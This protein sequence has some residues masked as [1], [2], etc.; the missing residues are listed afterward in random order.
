MRISRLALASALFWSSVGACGFS[1]AEHDAIWKARLLAAQFADAQA[2]SVCE[3]KP[4]SPLTYVDDIGPEDGILEPAL[5]FMVSRMIRRDQ[6]ALAIQN[7]FHGG[8]ERGGAKRGL[9]DV[10]SENLAVMKEYFRSNDFP[11]VEDIGESGV[12]ALLL[13][14][15]HAD[16]DPEF[17]KDIL[18]KMNA[19]VDSG[20][21]PEYLPS[22]LK[23]IRP[24]LGRPNGALMKSD[25]SSLSKAGPETPR[26]CYY[27]KRSALILEYL[28]DNYSFSN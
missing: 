23:S 11:G 2:A 26:Q 3:W 17:Q 7:A 24:Q 28:R 15:A 13:L 16:T 19:G 1:D 21:L 27:S 14:V 25:A 9:V 10:N 6:N 4:D 22:I 20:K 5:F 18:D 8:G 12:N